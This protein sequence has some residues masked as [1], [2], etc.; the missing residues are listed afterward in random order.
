MSP[1]YGNMVG[2][3]ASLKNFINAPKTVFIDLLSNNWVQTTDEDGNLIANKW[4][5]V[6]LQG[7]TDITKYSKV[8]LQPSAEQL[9]VFYEKDLAFVAENENGVVTVFCI[10]QKPMND[11]VIQ[12]I[13]TEVVVN[14]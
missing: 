4:S 11:Y 9:S 1:I 2:G 14:G 5:Q 12:S 10:G 3:A 13:V 6:V 7:N 8:D